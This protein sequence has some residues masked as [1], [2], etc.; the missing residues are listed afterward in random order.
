MKGIV[1]Q[2][3]AHMTF[4]SQGPRAGLVHAEA[5]SARRA[6][7]FPIGVSSLGDIGQV[8]SSL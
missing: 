8:V 7:G 6:A 2:L 5:G 4:L 1:S 3:C